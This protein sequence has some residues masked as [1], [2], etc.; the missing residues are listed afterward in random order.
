MSIL[1]LNLKISRFVL[2]LKNFLGKSVEPPPKSLAQPSESPFSG[3]TSNQNLNMMNTR[4]GSYDQSFRQGQCGTGPTSGNMVFNQQQQ[5]QRTHQHSQMSFMSRLS[6]ENDFGVYNGFG[7][8]KL[9]GGSSLTGQSPASSMNL[10]H[11]QRQQF[12]YQQRMFGFGTSEPEPKKKRGRP[13][14]NEAKEPGTKRAYKRRPK[15]V[16]STPLCPNNDV[17]NS[18]PL[19][20]MTQPL[21]RGSLSGVTSNRPHQQ[22]GSVYNF[23]DEETNEDLGS[24]L[25]R[26]LTGT[27]QSS[28]QKYS[29]GSSSDEE[30]PRPPQGA[31]HQQNLLPGSRPTQGNGPFQNYHFPH[32]SV[33]SVNP[34]QLVTG[35][36]QKNTMGIGTIGGIG[37]VRSVNSQQSLSSRSIVNQHQQMVN[38]QAKQAENLPMSEEDCRYSS[39]ILEKDKGIGIKIKI[40]KAP[41]SSNSSV[42]TFLGTHQQD[43]HQNQNSVQELQKQQNESKEASGISLSDRLQGN[44]RIAHQPSSTSQPSMTT[45]AHG[46]QMTPSNPGHLFPGKNVGAHLQ[47]QQN[48]LQHGNLSSSPS[49]LNLNST[50]YASPHSSNSFTHSST[51]VQSQA[52]FGSQ[53]GIQTNGLHQ[54]PMLHHHPQ[55]LNH[56]Q[57]QHQGV[58]QPNSLSGIRSGHPGVTPPLRSPYNSIPSP[59]HQPH[60]GQQIHQ[61]SSLSHSY[62]FANQSQG[63]NQSMVPQSQM[64][65]HQQSQKALMHQQGQ[66]MN[67]F[68]YNQG[69]GNS[70]NMQSQQ[71]QFHQGSFPTGAMNMGGGA[72]G[73]NNPYRYGSPLNGGVYAGYNSQYGMMSSNGQ[74]TNSQF[75]DQQFNNQFNCHQQFGNNMMFGSS[76]GISQSNLS[77][78]NRMIV[79]NDVMNQPIPP[80][81]R[82]QQQMVHQQS[83]MTQSGQGN[84]MGNSMISNLPNM[85]GNIGQPRI[86]PS[87]M[88]KPM[89][90]VGLVSPSLQNR[91]QPTPLV[92][93]QS[94]HSM[95]EHSPA[96]SMHNQPLTPNNNYCGPS[97]PQSCNPL[98]PIG[99]SMT[100]P[101]T[102][103]QNLIHSSVNQNPHGFQ[104]SLMSPLSSDDPN[105]MRSPSVCVSSSS[106]R[107]IR[108]PSKAYKDGGPA[109]PKIDNE[110]SLSSEKL[111]DHKE[112]FKEVGEEKFPSSV[113]VRIY[114][115]RNYNWKMSR[116]ILNLK[117]IVFVLGFVALERVKQSATGFSRKNRRLG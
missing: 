79:N 68:Y 70:F 92:S 91:Q 19:V 72:Y 35:L 48:Q 105:S 30:I 83:M 37:A 104:Q 17:N 80:T 9:T 110:E 40:K 97:T 66:T 54:Q 94:L 32:S 27:T 106:L 55:Q 103:G 71:N 99:M 1:C 59:S 87:S 95:S 75:Q 52:S 10:Q 64:H 6:S 113:Q 33:G 20:S 3:V 69:I 25:P 2:K 86:S 61:P 93:P 65:S 26:R 82:H 8:N 14:K 108:R 39:E 7:M 31:V 67:N 112:L 85:S 63:N 62:R 38:Q 88:H 84:L 47:S 36:H 4:P 12:S 57:S 18:I 109:T 49:T 53:V 76:N 56:Q 101:M 51:H 114:K 96:S 42:P 73:G 111:G 77:F 107:K 115:S 29:F 11:Q 98:T 13:R 60:F 45:L 58:Q 34:G 41:E 100:S 102:P 16:D 24:I 116:L 23:E 22:M 117:D 15:I 21:N 74:N 90:G 46:Q 43:V 5:Q 81:Y 78:G 28:K 89:P 44:E 50:G